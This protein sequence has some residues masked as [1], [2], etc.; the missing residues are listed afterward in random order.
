MASII[1]LCKTLF[2]ILKSGS[3][4]CLVYLVELLP[5]FILPVFAGHIGLV[6]IDAIGL[7]LAG[8]FLVGSAISILIGFVFQGLISQAC[9][10]NDGNAA[11]IL[12]QRTLIIGYLIYFAVGIPIMLNSSLIFFLIGQDIQVSHLAGNCLTITIPVYFVKFFGELLFRIFLAQ[13]KTTRVVIASAF[14]GIT[15]VLFEILFVHLLKFGLYGIPLGMTLALCVYTGVMLCLFLMDTTQGTYNFFQFHEDCMGRWPEL[16]TD[17]FYAIIIGIT[18]RLTNEACTF[19]A[20]MLGIIELAAQTILRR[21]TVFSHILTFGFGSPCISLIG[22]AIGC[23]SIADFQISVQATLLFHFSLS[24]SIAVLTVIFRNPLASLMSSNVDVVNLA[25]S[26]TLIVAFYDFLNLFNT[27][28]LDIFRAMDAMKF[29]FIVAVT[30]SY[31]LGLPLSFVLTLYTPLRLAG[32][33]WAML[34]YLFIQLLCYAGYLLHQDWDEKMLESLN[35]KTRLLASQSSKYLNPPNSLDEQS[36]GESL[37]GVD[38]V[39]NNSG[40][41]DTAH[42]D[43]PK[44]YL[45]QSIKHHL[46]QRAFLFVGLLSILALASALRIVSVFILHV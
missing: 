26:L 46:A 41:Q 38:N 35:E 5:H 39:C 14:Y 22:R 18:F 43:L 23:K 15:L 27:G 4:L 13:L 25:V 16:C 19:L 36:T 37:A 1:S 7:Y 33:Y 44:N 3:W 31:F 6:E 40:Q 2:E 20:G 28:F 17:Y 8:D 30:T 21:Y 11:R 24:F 9:G 12:F 34:L 10:S 45:F 42:A 32:F 29:P